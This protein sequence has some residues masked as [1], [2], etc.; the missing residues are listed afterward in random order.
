M[1]SYAQNLKYFNF[2]AYQHFFKIYPDSGLQLSQ[3]LSLSMNIPLLNLI[4]C[5][6]SGDYLILMTSIQ[7]DNITI[8]YYIWLFIRT[9]QY[10]KFITF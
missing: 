3:S 7:L 1:H 5:L 6:I 8:D 2:N 10:Y 9:T 4:L